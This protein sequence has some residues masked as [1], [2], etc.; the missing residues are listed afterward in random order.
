M[1]TKVKMRQHK[2]LKVSIEKYILF[3]TDFYTWH[4]DPE[5]QY[6]AFNVQYNRLLVKYKTK[7]YTDTLYSLIK[8]L[9]IKTGPT[10][11]AYPFVCYD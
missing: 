4:D 7:R 3:Y 1:S 10:N 9:L 8:T 5:I 11:I 6:F 2:Y